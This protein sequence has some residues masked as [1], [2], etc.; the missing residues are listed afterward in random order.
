[1]M[2]NRRLKTKLPISNKLLN[3]ELFNNIP[4]KLIKWQNIQKLHY[5]K[6]AHPLPEFN[7]CA[8]RLYNI[9]ET[10][11]HKVLPTPK[12]VEETGMNQVGSAE[13]GEL[14]TFCAIIGTIGNAFMFPKVWNKEAFY[15]E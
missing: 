5:D 12:V 2:F 14:A 10:G 6:T 15:K 13:W 4:E 7:T 11:I 9:D 8:E 1:M 3:A